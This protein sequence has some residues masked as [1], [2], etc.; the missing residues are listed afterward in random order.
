MH[1]ES[2]AERIDESLPLSIRVMMLIAFLVLLYVLVVDVFGF[3]S[4]L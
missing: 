3:A 2:D 1:E 4:L